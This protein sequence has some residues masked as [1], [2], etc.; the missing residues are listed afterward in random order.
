MNRWGRK[1]VVYLAGGIFQL[2][3]VQATAWREYV[4]RELSGQ[5]DFLDP[6]RRDYRGRE[7]ECYAEIVNGDKHDIRQSD[8]ILA[9]CNTPS[10]GT[11]MEIGYAHARRM[12][13]NGGTHI[14]GIVAGQRVSPWLRHHCDDIVDGTYAAIDKI[15]ELL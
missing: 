1:P 8:I 6:M 12:V 7:D 15:R 4:K 5:C 11:A 10:W 13:D 9:M 3:D 14:I 2:D